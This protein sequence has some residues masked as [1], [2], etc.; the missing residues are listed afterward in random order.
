MLRPEIAIYLY[1]HEGALNCV[2][3]RIENIGSGPAYQVRLNTDRPFQTE[4]G[5]DLREVGVFRKGL[6]FLAPKQRVEHFL[7]NIIGKFEKLIESPLRISAEY[8]D[9]LGT[10]HKQEFVLDFGEL[11]DLSRLGTP[12]LYEIATSTKKIQDD[13]GKLATGFNKLQVLT[14]PLSAY[15]HRREAQSLSWRLER[16]TKEQ[17]DEVQ[18][19]I[20]EKEKA[21]EPSPEVDKSGHDAV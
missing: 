8:K 6:N 18:Q 15:Q 21:R 14:E 13:L 10:Q 9:G 12:P 17:L 5:I 19:M 11:Q 4:D 20:V 7:V 16:L 1:P 2:L 3:L